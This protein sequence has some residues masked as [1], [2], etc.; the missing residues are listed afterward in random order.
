MVVD[1][2]AGAQLLAG[3][4]TL[5]RMP[6][7]L[8]EPSVIY[9]GLNNP[10][11]VAQHDPVLVGGYRGEHAVPPLERRLVGDAAQLGRAIDGDVVAHELDEGDAGG[12]RLTAVLEDG[13]GEGGEPP[14]AAAAAPSGHPGSGEAVPTAAA[15]A[16][17]RVFRV[18]PIGRCG[19][20]ERADV[21]LVATAPLVDGLSELQELVDGQARHE[22]SKGVRFSHIDLSHPPERPSRGIVTK[23]RSGW[24]HGQILCL[25]GKSMASG[26]LR[27]PDAMHYQNC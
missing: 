6:I 7:A 2:D 10:D 24:A 1:G 5:A 8:V 14:V 23:Q 9:V 18:R 25:A 3:Q 15:G 4:A 13:A 11:G 20:G 21:D 17:P 12:E 19:L 27:P 22:R 16:A 26:A